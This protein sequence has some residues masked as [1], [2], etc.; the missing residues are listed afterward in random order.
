MA[1][2]NAAGFGGTNEFC[3]LQAAYTGAAD[4]KLWSMALWINPDSLAADRW[5]LSGVDVGV[6]YLVRVLTNGQIRIQA[7]KVSI[8]S[9]VEGAS[10]AGDITT[11]SWQCFMASVD[12]ADTGKRHM[13][14]GDTDILSSWIT[15]VNENLRFTVADA[16]MIGARWTGAGGATPWSGGLS[17]LWMNFG[18]YID[19]SIEANRRIFVAA[20]GKCPQ[21]LADSADGDVGGLGQPILFLN[22][23]LATYQTNLGTGGGLTENGTLAS[24]T[25]PEI[26][27]SIPILRRRREFVGVH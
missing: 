7:S 3:D 6:Q 11:G 24:T 19:F 15:Y 4:S 21:L 1:N 12:M 18:Q 25:G 26:G 13:F 16:N 22:N 8:G 14:R 23:T 20:D 9:G 10:S 5:V 17:I 27:S 2:A